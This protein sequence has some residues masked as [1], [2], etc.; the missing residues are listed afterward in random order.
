MQWYLSETAEN[1]VHGF[2]QALQ[3]RCLPRALLTDNGSAM[4]SAE[5]E[6][7]LS[8]LSVHHKTILPYSP[9][10]SAKQEVLFATVEERLMAMLENVPDLSLEELNRVT[11]AWYEL[12][13]NRARHAEL[14]VAPVDR[15]ASAPEVLRSS[16]SSEVLRDAFRVQARRRQP[17][18]DGSNSLDGVR[19]EI[20]SRLRHFV[21]LTVR[22]ARWDLGL[23]HVVEERSDHMLARIYPLDRQANADG[24][25]RALE[26]DTTIDC[27]EALEGEHEEPGG[28]RYPPLSRR[29]LEEYSASG[30]P[31]AYLP[32]SPENEEGDRT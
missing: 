16:P 5:F 13:D 23:V 26:E 7:G 15:Y 31:P 4:V 22:Y 9:H 25:R 8:R 18:S 6:E 11:R 14:G 20:P 2:N 21:D 30:L 17:R 29:L 24:L 1:L 27:D 28:G 12:D 3:K 10:Q 19:F 32:R